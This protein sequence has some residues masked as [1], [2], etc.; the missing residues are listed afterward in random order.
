MRI[1]HWS[2][3]CV[4][5]LL[6]LSAR[7][8]EL[9]SLV[10]KVKPSV[11]FLEIIDS[12]GTPIGNGTGFVVSAD[13]Q[14][15]TNAH[16]VRPAYDMRAKLADGS[17]RSVLGLLAADE[18]HDV[19]IVKLEGGGYPPL[20]LGDSSTLAEGVPVAV[21]GNPLGL[22]WTYTEGRVA[23]LRRELPAD[24][25][26]GISAKGP[27]V[28]IAAIIAPGSSG[29]PVFTED[30]RVIGVAQ[31]GMESGGALGFAVP[32]EMVKELRKTLRQGVAP[33]PFH[34]F[35]LKNLI[36][37]IAFYGGLAGLVIWYRARKRKGAASPLR[38]G[39]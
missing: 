19:A 3:A 13:G 37:S 36:F 1:G 11:V 30:A 6:S 25:A 4:L 38:F 12:S 28:Q 2:C 15:V 17:V 39:A 8:V 33:Q 16:V 7:A 24:L 34:T 18:E 20:D 14:V 27:F 10:G 22:S 29:S 31:S 35:P 5:L 23:A 32:I 21:I 26:A 9:S